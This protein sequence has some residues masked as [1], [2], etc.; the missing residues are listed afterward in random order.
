MFGTT[1]DREKKLSL[2]YPYMVTCGRNTVNFINDEMD[3]TSR[4]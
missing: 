2:V 3:V 1:T 4:S